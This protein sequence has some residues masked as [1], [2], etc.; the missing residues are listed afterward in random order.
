MSFFSNNIKGS[1]VMV[2]EIN[3]MMCAKGPNKLICHFLI[4]KIKQKGCF[5]LIH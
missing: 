2:I 3:F 5:D 4:E 1:F